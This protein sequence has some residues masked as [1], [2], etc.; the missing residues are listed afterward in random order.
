MTDDDA[1][2]TRLRRVLTT[3]QRQAL[4]NDHER[5]WLSALR[6]KGLDAGRH[7]FLAAGDSE[8][9]EARF[10][11]VLRRGVPYERNLRPD[12]LSGVAVALQG[13][14]EAALERA[15][16]VFSPA[17][18]VLGAFVSSCAE[19][20]LKLEGLAEFAGYE[21]CVTSLDAAHGLCIERGFYDEQGHSIPEG[22][23]LLR[24]WGDLVP[25]PG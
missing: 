18:G 2:S 23:L 19:V 15:A 5:A 3:R 22:V 13:L 1:T 11:E 7:P 10:F 20:A 14:P 6:S 9:V 4:I 25:P 16:V 12:E 21:L 24:A 17:E 8:A